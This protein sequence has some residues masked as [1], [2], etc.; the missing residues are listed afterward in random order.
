MILEK[1]TANKGCM[2]PLIAAQMVPMKMY[3]HSELLRR[4]TVKNDTGGASSSCRHKGK[5]Q[6]SACVSASLSL[7]QNGIAEVGERL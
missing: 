7:F 5:N 3:G 4:S 1:M 2:A 6:V